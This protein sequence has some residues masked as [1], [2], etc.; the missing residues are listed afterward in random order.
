MHCSL[1]RMA[2]ASFTFPVLFQGVSYEVFVRTR[3]YIHEFLHRVSDMFEVIL[4]TASKKVYADKLVNLLD[5]ERKHIKYVHG[6]CWEYMIDI[7]P[8]PPL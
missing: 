8:V 2:D 4:F 7:C 3:P 6:R 1:Q 5:P